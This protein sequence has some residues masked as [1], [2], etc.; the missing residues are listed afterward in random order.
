MRKNKTKCE[1]NILFSVFCSFT[2][3]WVGI[4]R[5]VPTYTSERLCGPDWINFRYCVISI[6]IDIGTY[7]V[8]IIQGICARFALASP[9]LEN[10]SNLNLIVGEMNFWQN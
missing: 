2:L 7:L 4:L 3:K 9:L 1:Q 6:V 8:L 5:D 10:F